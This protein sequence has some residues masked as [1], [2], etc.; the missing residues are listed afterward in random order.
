MSKVQEYEDELDE[1]EKQMAYV[2]GCGLDD[3]GD[4]GIDENGKV[5]YS[6]PLKKDPSEPPEFICNHSW[7]PTKL[8][9][10]TVYDCKHCGI[11]K[12]EEK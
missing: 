4:Y 9:Y 12:E 11:K 6:N 3:F 2:Y 10:S 8:V 7:Q 1:W 5:T